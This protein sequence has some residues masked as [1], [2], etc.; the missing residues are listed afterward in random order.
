MTNQPITYDR[1]RAS[2]VCIHDNKILL[3][4]RINLEKRQGE[5]EYYVI[6]G[7]GVE[8]GE[9]IEDAVIR[10]VKEETNVDVTV[11]KLFYE[12]DDFN[13]KGGLEKYY[14]YLCVFVNG[15]AKL[16]EDSEEAKEMKAGVHFYKPAWIDLT[17]LKNVTLYPTP[18]KAKLIKDLN[19]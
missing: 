9:S 18:L 12:L 16:R 3:I 1:V 8:D 5:Q 15:E 19:L 6:P 2:G 11:D 13:Q 17:S 10:E 4:H 7:G 14:C